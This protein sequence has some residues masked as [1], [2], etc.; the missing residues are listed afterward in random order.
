[1]EFKN[2]LLTA[3]PF[4]DRRFCN[5][6]PAAIPTI[7]GG[8]SK[9]YF[10]DGSDGAVTISSN[11]NWATTTGVDDTGVVIK[12][13]TILTIDAGVVV[14]AANRA[15]AMLV[16]VTGDCTINGE[17]SMTKRGAVGAPSGDCVI[18]RVPVSGG[19]STGTAFSDFSNETQEG[20]PTTKQ[21]GAPMVGAAGGLG[22]TMYGATAGVNGVNGQC[23]G[24]GSGGSYSY[25]NSSGS[26]S[27]GTSYSGGSGGGGCAWPNP[28]SGNSA[29][30]A[31]PYGGAGG[32][33]RN[34][35]YG[36]GGGGAGNPGGGSDGGGG[37]GEA[38]TGGVLF[39]IVGGNLDIGAVGVISANGGKGGDRTREDNF[40]GNGGGGS[41]GGSL[42]VLYA[43]TLSNSG[44]LHATGGAGG[45]G[46]T[47]PST[48]FPGGKGGDGS[49]TIEQ[50]E[51]A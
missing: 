12:N 13:F 28:G 18:Y 24:G 35:S 22:S 11:T 10:G 6:M 33:G 16:Y 36:D 3:T 49:V 9:N 43:G 40:T 8:S 20:S 42:N 19:G 38:G 1:M 26:G 30:D 15:R 14:T 5:I 4:S 29:G 46:A 50:I 39:L 44:S 45:V 23:G 51:A 34:S 48:G 17:L 41:G 37:S 2:N 31:E 7:A 47:A 25:S 32:R 27:A 21:Y